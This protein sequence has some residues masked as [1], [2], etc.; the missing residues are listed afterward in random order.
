MR[1]QCPLTGD[2]AETVESPERVI[3]EHRK[4]GRYAVDKNALAALEADTDVRKRMAHWL[5]EAHSSGVKIPNL[6]LEHVHLFERLFDLDAKI[7]EW[8]ELRQDIKEAD[9]DRLWRKLRLEWNYNSNHI[10]GNTLTYHE[11]ELLLIHGRT[12]S[13]HPLRHYE[14]MKAH[15]VAIDYAR[16]LADEE[17][18][19]A[20]IAIRELNKILL[21]DPFWKEAQTPDGMSTRKRIV[22]GEYKT[23]PNH[24]LTPTGELQRFAEPHETPAL[25]GDWTMS[26]RRDL[27]RCAYPLPLFLAESHWSFL[28]IHPFDDGNGRTVRL[29]ANYILLR[30]D[31]PPIVIKGQ[32]RDRYIGCLGNADLNNILPLAEFMLE[33]MLWSLA[34]AIRAASG[35]SIEEPE[36]ID[37]EIDL[38]VQRKHGEQQNKRGI[39]T[40]DNVVFLHILPTI[41]ALQRRLKR[42]SPSLFLSFH[43]HSHLDYI[44]YQIL[45][46]P[47]GDKSTWERTKKSL[48]NEGFCLDDPHQ[49]EFGKVFRLTNYIGSGNRGFN[50]ELFVLWTLDA[51]G[52]TFEVMIDDEPQPSL[53]GRTP[54][55]ELE[56]GDAEPDARV[57]EICRSMMDVINGRSQSPKEGA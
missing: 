36:D 27:K 6:A 54:Y 32:D 3:V 39:Q 19:I 8:H 51:E 31:L 48:V 33:N 1:N 49:I 37:K 45:G 57:S 15:D 14:E 42:F 12:S 30:K 18:D 38:F 17:R 46:D 23:Q 16:R 9:K 56:A 21:K 53:G 11:T 24:V 5:A 40:L 10:E 25:M 52:F 4:I 50:L 35:E 2:T 13:G 7:S 28:R 43:A 47:F 26:F 34:L 29:L 22:P 55:S 44:G 41:D 20:E